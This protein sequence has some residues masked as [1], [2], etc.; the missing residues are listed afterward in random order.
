M[1]CFPNLKHNNPKSIMSMVSNDS[2]LF[3]KENKEI[4]INHS[5]LILK[6]NSNVES[7]YKILLIFSFKILILFTKKLEGGPDFIN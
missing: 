3:T 1:G 2:K 6:V 4:K 5:R 7:E